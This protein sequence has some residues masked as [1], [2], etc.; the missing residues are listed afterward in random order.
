MVIKALIV[1]LG[2]WAI[3]LIGQA[4]SA[5][6]LDRPIVQCS[7]IGLLLGDVKTGVMMGGALEAVYMGVNQIGG[8][9]SANAG[10]GSVLSTC[11]VILGGVPFETAVAL[12]MPVAAATNVISQLM[13]MV[14]PMVQ[15]FLQKLVE[16]GEIKKYNVILFVWEMLFS[17]G[18]NY[19]I[20]FLM[21]V[22]GID[23]VSAAITAFP[24]SVLRGFTAAGNAL[25]ALGLANLAVNIWTTESAAFLVLG[26]TLAKT[27]GL[28]SITICI[29]SAVAAIIIFFREKEMLDLKSSGAA[30]EKGD[31]FYD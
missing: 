21:I 19:V 7:I 25:A 8:V 1:C 30:V 23:A 20:Y 31:D 29:I 17:K 18:P 11:L 9:S 13:S 16:K 24:A 10:A 15:P 4:L 22:L 28:N 3:A 12:S 2:L 5:E 27:M 26:F 6:G 14:R